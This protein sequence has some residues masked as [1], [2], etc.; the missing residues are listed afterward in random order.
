[1]DNYGNVIKQGNDRATLE[2]QGLTTQNKT[3]EYTLNNILPAQLEQMKQAFE[4]GDAETA[5][6]LLV[7][8]MYPAIA[9][10]QIN[11]NDAS[12]SATLTNAATNAAHAGDSYASNANALAWAKDPTN[13]DNQIK[14][15]SMN[16]A[17]P[18]NIYKIAQADS[19]TNK[20]QPTMANILNQ[21]M[22]MAKAGTYTP[23]QQTEYVMNS[24][25]SAEEKQIIGNQL[26]LPN[27][28]KK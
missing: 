9:Q 22:A 15:W 20:G 21:T 3:A 17:N 4:K 24:N 8:K 16:P 23:D 1:L 18:D 13:P 5:Y 12:A 6:Q 27:P 25:L 2:N 19:A 7:N 28:K 26:G 14:A 10:S 11:Q